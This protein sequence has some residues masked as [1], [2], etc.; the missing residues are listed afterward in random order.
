MCE[1]LVPLGRVASIQWR[2]GQAAVLVQDTCLLLVYLF[3]IFFLGG[4]C[5][6]WLANLSSLTRDGTPVSPVSAQNP[7]HW[8]AGKLARTRIL[9]RKMKRMGGSLPFRFR[10]RSEPPLLRSQAASV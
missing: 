8:T 10:G 1:T 6:L 2:E 3:F 7:K 9:N 5:S 4:G